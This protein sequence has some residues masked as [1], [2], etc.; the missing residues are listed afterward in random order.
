MKTLD[1]MPPETALRRE[2][3]RCA[4]NWAR[5]LILGASLTAFLYVSLS[6]LASAQDAKLTELSKKYTAL[7]GRLQ[8]AGGLLAERN[9]L[10]RNY[11]A[12]SLL[13]NDRKTTEV[14]GTIGSA[15]TP[16]SHLS[17]LQ[18]DRRIP[19]GEGPADAPGD[20]PA[21]ETGGQLCIRG[22]APGHG[23]VGDVIKSMIASG[24]F[25]EVR[26]VWTKDA[27]VA[28]APSRIEFEIECVLKGPAASGALADGALAKGGV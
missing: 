1:L 20:A 3:R 18:I 12:I 11:E 2:V 6:A 28:G 19:E 17:F 10:T 5:R 7:N 25:S 4:S 9:K 14:L 22:V 24:V 26:L 23:Q 13:A 21:E 27:S 16:E 8:R 15:L